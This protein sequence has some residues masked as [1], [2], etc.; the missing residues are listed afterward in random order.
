M[1]GVTDPER[2][3]GLEEILSSPAAVV[4]MVTFAAGLYGVFKKKE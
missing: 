3:R 1:V 2:I 4:M